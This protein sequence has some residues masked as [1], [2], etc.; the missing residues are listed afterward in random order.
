LCRTDKPEG[1]DYGWAFTGSGCVKCGAMGSN[2]PGALVSFFF[3]IMIAIY[4]IT[5]RVAHCRTKKMAGDSKTLSMLMKKKKILTRTRVCVTQVM[6]IVGFAQSLCTFNFSLSVEFPQAFL[7]MS[8]SL[9]FLNFDVVNVTNQ[10]FCWQTGYYVTLQIVFWLQTMLCVVVMLDYCRSKAVYTT[11]DTAGVFHVKFLVMT[12]FTM[13]PQSV[14]TFLAFLLCEEIEGKYYMMADFR[15]HCYDDKWSSYASVAIPGILV[16]VVGTPAFFLGILYYMYKAGVLHNVQNAD[17][18]AFLFI[19]FKPDFWYFEI[20]CLLVKCTLVGV[21]M[22]IDK[23]SATQVAVTLF[24]SIIFCFIA[25]TTAP[26]K[27]TDNNANASLVTMTMVLTLFTALLLKTKIYEIDGWDNGVLNGFVMA[28]NF[29]TMFLFTYRF[30]RVQGNF[31][32]E[33]YGP[34]PCQTCFLAFNRMMGWKPIPE[35]G[36][37]DPEPEVVAVEQTGVVV[38]ISGKKAANYW[39]QTFKVVS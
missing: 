24:L 33:H 20:Y 23:G 21:V 1:D 36:P 19:N 12:F 32:C 28:V 15:E 17:K 9:A 13:Y 39:E 2:T 10:V 11:D 14:K 26:Y 7:D 29:I 34:K 30:V 8:D 37:P 5:W 27:N 31:L 22:F 4:E 38:A 16:Y 18:F 35:D 6:I 3:L 25:L